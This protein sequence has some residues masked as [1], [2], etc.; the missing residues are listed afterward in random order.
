MDDNRLN[1]D[2]LTPTVDSLHFFKRKKLQGVQYIV[3][4][5]SYLVILAQT[6]E[7]QWL[8][9]SLQRT[10][11]LLLRHLNFLNIHYYNGPH[12]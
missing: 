12:R 10:H 6:Q 5:I 3:F 8:A 4:L 9:L 2:Q 11:L 7:I 1:I